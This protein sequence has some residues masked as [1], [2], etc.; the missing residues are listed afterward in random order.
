MLERQLEHLVR[1]VDDLLDVARISRGRVELRRERILLSDV[2]ADAVEAV[3]PLIVAGDHHLVVTTPD[4]PV[5]AEGD[6][7]RLVQVI[8][9]LLNNAAKYTPDGGTLSVSLSVDAGDAVIAVRDNGVGIPEAQIANVFDIFA[10]VDRNLDRSQGG[11][12]IGLALARSLVE[13]HGG[14]IDAE[15]PVCGSRQAASRCEY[16]LAAQHRT[17]FIRPSQPTARRLSGRRWCRCE[18]S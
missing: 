6:P 1:L 13:L 8:T 9:N 15:S 3:R 7:V 11:L 12:G 2:I 17:R 10:Q 14:R 5:V 18:C 16:R 4:Q